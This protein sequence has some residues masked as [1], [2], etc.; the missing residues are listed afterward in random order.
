MTSHPIGASF[1][2][3]RPGIASVG[4][5]RRWCTVVLGARCKSFVVQRC[6]YCCLSGEEEIDGLLLS[7][8]LLWWWCPYTY[9]MCVFIGSS[10]GSLFLRLTNSAC[11]TAIGGV[12]LRSRWCGSIIQ[13]D[14]FNTLI[15]F[16]G[17]LFF[18]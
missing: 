14:I 17:G 18:A 2:V 9:S 12:S 8:L 4:R 5:P 1:A 7:L 13:P 3:W 16:R 6:L 10:R 11:R 15:S